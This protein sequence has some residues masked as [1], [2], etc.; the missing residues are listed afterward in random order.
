MQNLINSNNIR[1][2]ED[3]YILLKNIDT[4]ALYFYVLFFNLTVT[5]SII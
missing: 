2:F 3:G 1:I 5:L 4:K